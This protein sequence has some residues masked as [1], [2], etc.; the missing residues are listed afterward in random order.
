MEG[1]H[2]LA[3]I[4]SIDSAPCDM[5]K[6]RQVLRILDLKIERRVPPQQRDTL[7]R[8]KLLHFCLRFVVVLLFL[9]RNLLFLF[10]FRIA[11][12]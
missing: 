5:E 2:K 1:V 7:P 12:A 9:L 3:V 4:E 8:M 6:G 10:E 11:A